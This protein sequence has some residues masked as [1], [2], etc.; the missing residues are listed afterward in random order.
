MTCSYLTLK[1]LLK[2]KE[3]VM[4]QI[5]KEQI[6]M[7]PMLHVVLTEKRDERLPTVIYYHG[8]TSEKDSS[9][10]L[11]YKLAERGIRTILPDSLYHGERKEAISD[12]QLHLSFWDIV[13]QNIKELPKIVTYLENKQLLERENI[14]IGGTSMGAITTYG[15][16]KTYDWIKTA[17]TFMGTP[18]LK[19]FATMLIEQINKTEPGSITDEKKREVLK[20]I[21]PYDISND[22]KTLNERPLFIWHGDEDPVVPFEHDLHFYEQIKHEYKTQD[23]LLFLR[24]KNRGHHVSSWSIREG[25]DWL[26]KF[27]RN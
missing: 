19:T 13:V 7:I 17:A 10:T 4:I 26:Y 2:R 8:F 21:A 6:D 5:T 9:L 16:L 11:A 14:G 22:S 25:A 3:T 1:R 18:Q 12:E 24:E 15:A 23:H 27:L 20:K